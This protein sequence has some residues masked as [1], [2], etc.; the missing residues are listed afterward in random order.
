MRRT[1]RFASLSG[2][3]LLGAGLLFSATPATAATIEFTVACDT[4]QP[5]TTFFPV[6]PGDT[7]TINHSGFN[8]LYDQDTQTDSPLDPSGG[9]TELA[10][11]RR[12]I[13]L[14]NNVGAPCQTQ[15]FA[16][17]LGAAPETLP[18]GDLLVSERIPLAG[19]RELTVAPNVNP[20]QHQFPD[21]PAC[22]VWAQSH[23]AHVY[24]EVTLTVETAGTYTIKGISS[25]P[26]GR[27]VPLSPPHPIEDPFLA[28]YDTFDPD[29]PDDGIVT[30][31]DNAYMVG[32]MN[33]VEYRADLS[34]I[35]G[36]QPILSADLE[37][38][39]YSLI[40]MTS[41]DLSMDDVQN[42]TEPGSDVPYPAGPMSV[43]IEVWGPAPIV[44]TPA[45]PTPPALA[46]TGGSVDGTAAVA[47]AVLALVGAA[48]LVAGRRARR[49]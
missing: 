12:A 49:A 3:I 8:A 13:F 46:A 22:Q 43:D 37:P 25:D 47:G 38:G 14:N 35:S 32:D 30:C 33:R 45:T 44:A 2:T 17:V 18:P 21:D 36:N 5:G 34:F 42:G 16:R 10:A 39:T 28:L 9:S 20:W 41:G 31:N 29:A 19:D 15:F 48:L 7:V 40:L 11:G 4:V 23:G 24:T 26:P 1:A 6:L 27:T